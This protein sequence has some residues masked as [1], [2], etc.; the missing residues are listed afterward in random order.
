[1]EKVELAV[2]QWKEMYA[3]KRHYVLTEPS[4]STAV[5]WIYV[6][7]PNPFEKEKKSQQNKNLLKT[8][9]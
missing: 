2:V 7:S 5:F 8:S 4:H 3:A 9:S 6:Q 1:M